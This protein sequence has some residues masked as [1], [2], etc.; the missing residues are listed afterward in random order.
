M[1]LRTINYI[2]VSL[3][4]SSQKLS[5]TQGIQKNLTSVHVD[6]RIELRKQKLKSS[7]E[8]AQIPCKIITKT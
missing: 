2:R 3:K 6:Q 7:S 5:Y 4:K 8:Q 1:A